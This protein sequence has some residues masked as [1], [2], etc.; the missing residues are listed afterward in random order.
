[1]G[2]GQGLGKTEEGGG[3]GRVGWGVGG[4]GSVEV[5]SAVN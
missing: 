1:M 3:E 2:S 4:S 5:N